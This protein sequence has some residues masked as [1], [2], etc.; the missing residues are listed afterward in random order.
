MEELFPGEKG[1]ATLYSDC[2]KALINGMK[3]GPIGVKVAT[4][5]EYA[6]IL[7]ICQLYAHLRTEV[8]P[9]WTPGHSNPNNHR[10][11]QTPYEDAYMEAP[12]ITVCHN[13][14]P[15]T[16]GLPQ[17][18]TADIHYAPLKT[19][20][21]RFTNWS[22][23]EFDLVDWAGLH[24]AMLHLPRTRRIAA[25][26]LSHG[27]WNV[28]AQNHCFYNQS[29]SSRQASLEAL[30]IALTSANPPPPPDLTST[31]MQQIRDWT[32]THQPSNIQS[33]GLFSAKL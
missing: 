26:K 11:E 2:K 33:S 15:I 24:S 5:D 29:P 27:L 8:T 9:L 12:I 19:K 20:I 3:K 30:N 23:K 22:E 18:V 6:L 28:N 31:I 16:S 14:L 17:L 4:Q 21:F 10:G 7:A 1:L 32:A 13:S 25:A